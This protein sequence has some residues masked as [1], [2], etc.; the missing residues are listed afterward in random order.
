MVDWSRYLA[1]LC[2]TYTQ[3]WQVYTLTDVVER[4]RD[5]AEL[6]LL[7]FDFGLMVQTVK[8]DREERGKEEEKVERLTVLEVLLNHH[9]IQLGAGEQIEFRHQLIQEYYTAEY[10]LKVLQSRSAPLAPQFW[11]NKT[12]LLLFSPPKLGGLGGAIR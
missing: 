9:L 4:K 6:S 8:R 3:W 10:L 7:L 2:K 12:K 1:S 5:E 11:G